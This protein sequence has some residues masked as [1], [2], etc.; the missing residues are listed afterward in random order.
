MSDQTTVRTREIPFCHVSEH[1]QASQ[2]L[3]SVNPDV[4]AREALEQA[5]LILAAV[6][7]MAKEYISL[8]LGDDAWGMVSLIDMAKAVVD[9]VSFG[10]AHQDKPKNPIDGLAEK[11]ARM[12]GDFCA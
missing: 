6:R 5:S 9:S 1:N 4:D 12:R 11:N 8:D 2:H 3:F 10:V 7:C